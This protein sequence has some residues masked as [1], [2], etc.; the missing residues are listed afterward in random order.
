MIKTN[1]LTNTRFEFE[2]LQ[3]VDFQSIRGF[4]GDVAPLY[5]NFDA[6]FYFKFCRNLAS[7]Q[8]KMAIAHDGSQMLGVAL[9]K[10]D[11]YESKIC[12]FYVSPEFRGLGVGC[13]LMDLALNTLDDSNAFIT[14]SDERKEELTPL[15]SSRGFRITSSQEGLYRDLCTEH[16]FRL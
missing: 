11:L 5:P 4:L 13:E 1:M 9:L 14:V 10:Q 2:V 8:R 7:G 15:L 3:D 6:W 12:T 16:F